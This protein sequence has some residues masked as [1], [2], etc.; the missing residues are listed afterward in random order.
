[1]KWQVSSQKLS[2]TVGIPLLRTVSRTLRPGRPCLSVRRVA[3]EPGTH[4]RIAARPV[5]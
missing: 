5:S 3:S 4:G 1:M 2:R